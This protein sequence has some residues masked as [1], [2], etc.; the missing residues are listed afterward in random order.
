M[1]IVR[2][3]DRGRAE[4]TAVSVEPTHFVEDRDKHRRNILED[5]FGFGAIEKGRMLPEF[6]GD[7]VND[8]AAAVVQ[9]FIRFFEQGSLL[10]DLEN[11]ERDPGENIITARNAAMGQ[12]FGKFCGVPVDDM[13]SRIAG[14]LAL[15][16]PRKSRVQLE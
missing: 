16:I 12:L 5:V 15:Q 6:V 9:S 14:E 10:I 8:K 3:K 7:L 13:D 4:R 1:K 2:G 11:T